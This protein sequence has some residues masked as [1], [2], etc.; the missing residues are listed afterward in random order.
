MERTNHLFQTIE[1]LKTQYYE[2]NEKKIIFKR[3]QKLDCAEAISSHIELQKL[4]DATI[5]IIPNTSHIFFNYPTFKTFAH[6]GVY[7]AIVQHAMT[8]LN[9][10]ID[11]YGSYEMHIN[12]DTFSVSAVERYNEGIRLYCNECLKSQCEY[13]SKITNMHMYNVPSLIDAIAKLL[14][15][16]I[17]PEIKT[18]IIKYTREES[19]IVIPQLYAMLY[20][21]CDKIEQTI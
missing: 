4:L 9:Y 20:N 1:D 14:D 12:L 2:Q 7:D 17:H 6:P 10:C 18:K 3:K 21:S 19:N 16:F 13:Y 11:K 5:F 8:Q 15:G